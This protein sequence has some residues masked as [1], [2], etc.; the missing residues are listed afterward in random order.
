MKFKTKEFTRTNNF[1]SHMI[2]GS[3]T[4]AAIDTVREIENR[5]GETEVDIELKFNGVEIDIRKFTQFLEEAWDGEVKKACQ[6]EAK[7]LFEKMKHEF[8]S[9]NSTNAQLNKIR[10]QLIKATNHLKNVEEN[11]ERISGE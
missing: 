4:E 6:P 7:K 9:K 10:E 3:I 1:L 2:L 8:K 11:V 5:N